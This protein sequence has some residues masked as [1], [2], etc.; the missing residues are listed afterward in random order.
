MGVFRALAGIGLAVIVTGSIGCAVDRTG[1]GVLQARRGDAE[2]DSL[3]PD[4]GGEA[5]ADSPDLSGPSDAGVDQSQDQPEDRRE[6]AVTP[7]PDARA[8]VA[9]DVIVDHGSEARAEVGPD[10]RPD[11]GAE[12]PVDMG[13]DARPAND[14]AADTRPACGA[15]GGQH[16][17]GQSCVDNTSVASCGTSCVPC[18]VPANGNATCNGTTCGISCNA[19]FVPA[20][21]SCIRSCTPACEAG[22]VTVNA[23]GNRFT[24]VTAGPSGNA[25]SCGGGAAPD[26]VFRVVLTAPSDLFVATHGTPFDTVI[27]LRNGC[28]GTELACNDNADG[29]RTSVLNATNLP[30]GTYLVF[31][32]GAAATDAGAFSVDIFISPTSTS[33]GDSCGRPARIANA[34]LAGTTCGLRDDAS[35]QPTCSTADSSLDAVYY[36]VLDEPAT[37]RFDTCTAT[38]LDTMIYVRD[39]CSVPATQQICNDDACNG[40]EGSPNSIQ[41]RASATLAAGVHYVVVDSLIRNACGAFTLTPQNVPE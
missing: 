2:I 7:V 9:P 4:D 21:T 10:L 17:C 27:Y 38:C 40:C 3:W 25:G 29:R 12:L 33:A 35:P 15:D 18:N 11:A 20:G 1:L 37:V 14:V 39:T 28:C 32:D 31:V 24:G 13:T 8:E 41:S 5:D 6:D 23:P 34:A 22:A 26:A 19:N 30:A 36:F 16:L